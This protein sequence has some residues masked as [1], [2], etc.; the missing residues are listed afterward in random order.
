[1]FVIGHKNPDT[2]SICA[3]ISYAK[4]KNELGIKCEARRL[5]PINEETKFAL[6]YFGFE[7]PDMLYDARCT[8]GDISFDKAI[9]ISEN[10]SCNQALNLIAKHNST[11]VV[12]DNHMLK[13]VISASNL[14]SVR[15]M[16]P[17]ERHKLMSQTTPELISKDFNGS[18]LVN[19]NNFKNNGHI[20]VFST[21]FKEKGDL[22]K[23]SILVTDNKDLLDKA[24]KEEPGLVIY[25]G[26]KLSKEIISLYKK[27]DVPLIS[28][29]LHLED[30]LRSVNESIPV[31]LL[32][33]TN[34][35]SFEINDFVNDA[36]KKAIKTRYRC[37][38][39]IDDSMKVCGTVSRYHLYDYERNKLI[40]VDHSS[41]MQTVNGVDYA[42]IVEIIDH[43]HIGDIE[44][45]H[46]INYR[47]QTYGSTCSIIYEM[48]KEN[49]VRPTKSIAGLML[50]AI[51]SDTLFFESNTTTKL[52]KK[53]ASELAKIAGVSI[54]SYANKLLAASVNLKHA[55]IK[56]ILERDLKKYK[57][58]SI[59]LAVGQTN[60]DKLSD[61]Q[62]RID[63]FK[64]TLSKYQEDKSLDLLVMMFTHVKGEGTYF[65]FF[66]NKKEAISEVID[67]IIDDNSGFD[68]YII[69]RKQ[70]LIPKLSKVLEN[71]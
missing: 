9:E 55:N 54:N 13:G 37:F 41:K 39:V 58:N 40:L 38:P 67:T 6:N 18:I 20:S 35:K 65:L 19:S 48:Y 47:N 42:E 45:D 31:K 8:I 29:E 15:L 56:E 14:N 1:M 68:P 50:S 62:L 66:G 34:I 51:I 2:D 5:G 49:K 53:Y 10:D 26:K 24:L 44:T 43:H 60:F 70:Q 4:L 23:G 28:T 32:M 46:P 59:K 36:A 17:T 52:D 7:P 25:S 63:E 3:S 33:K 27:K 64:E 22:Y 11:L 12:T 21:H 61:I 30:I 71:Y 16:T 69:S 57:F